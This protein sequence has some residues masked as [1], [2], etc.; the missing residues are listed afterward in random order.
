[1]NN[2]LED[3]KAH[4]TRRTVMV[5][6]M[7]LGAFLTLLTETFLNNALPTIMKSFS[8]SQTTVQWLSTGYLMVAGLMIPISAWVFKRFDVKKTYLLMMMIFLLGSIMGY[9]APNFTTLLLGR[10]VQAVAAGSLIP[11]I[12]NVVLTVY[13]IEKR[14]AAMGMAGIVVAFAPAIGPTLSGFIIDDYGWRAL[15]LILIPLTIII[16]IL[17]LIFTRSINQTENEPIDLWSLF[18]SM[19]GFGMLLYSFSMIGNSGRLSVAETIIFLVGFFLIALFVRRQLAVKSPLIEVRVF[20]NRTFTLTAILSAISNISMLGVELVMPLYLQN[21]HGVSALVSGVILLPGA[22]V[23]AVIN[24][25]S[26]RLFDKYGIFKLSLVGY[27]I[28][29]LGT[30]PMFT[31]GLHANLILVSTLYAIRMIGIALIMMP[32]FTAGVNA[33]DQKLAIHGNAASSTVRQIA[34]S[35]GTA[36]LMMIVALFSTSNNHAS[37]TAL[38]NGYHAAFVVAFIMA[39]LGLPLSFSLRESKK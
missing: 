18:L 14:G 12:Q 16:F 28:L 27:A 23:M 22:L 29:A 2:I 36:I 39:V 31:F 32:T 4:P 25:I 19:T 8:I 7:L 5:I 38:N 20:K 11:L 34:G 37:L 30:L 9:L 1:M 24:P 17:A 26:G 15:F 21:V 10:L 33:L 13:P 35:L 3:I 6:V